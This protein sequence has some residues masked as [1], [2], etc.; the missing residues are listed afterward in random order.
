MGESRPAAG[1]LEAG[2]ADEQLAQA[3]DRGV[4]AWA[5]GAQVVE[6]SL[7]LGVEEY[8]RSRPASS[9]PSSTLVTGGPR[10]LR[11]MSGQKREVAG[12]LNALVLIVL[13]AMS[14]SDE[15]GV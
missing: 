1:D 10:S 13:P 11:R 3:C 2:G 4:M 7:R 5:V 6:P 12:A 8:P 15:D 9:L 14:L